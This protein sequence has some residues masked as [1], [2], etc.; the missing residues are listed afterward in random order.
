M[1]NTST[2]DGAGGLSLTSQ[3]LKTKALEQFEMIMKEYADQQDPDTLV[4]ALTERAMRGAVK[5]NDKAA[6]DKAAKYID[7]LY[8]SH[9]R[10]YHQFKATHDKYRDDVKNN[11]RS[12]FFRGYAKEF[13]GVF[14]R[15][16][17]ALLY[18]MKASDVSLT[19]TPIILN[20]LEQIMRLM[21]LICGMVRTNFKSVIASLDSSHAAMEAGQKER[22]AA[23]SKKLTDLDGFA[24]KLQQTFGQSLDELQAGIDKDKK[25]Q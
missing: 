8:K 24:E 22:V 7:T 20:K 19:I 13:D 12:E 10:T 15:Y 17:K 5:A 18:Y 11:K 9:M 14:G 21:I 4:K 16:E 2:K 6:A 3:K 1:G 25:K 23:L